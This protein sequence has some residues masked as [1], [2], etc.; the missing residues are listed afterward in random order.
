MAFPEILRQIV[1]VVDAIEH[2]ETM[3]VEERAALAL[4]GFE[5]FD[6]LRHHSPIEGAL[7]EEMP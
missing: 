4:V 1:A 5:R 7:K 2:D 3:T 6:R